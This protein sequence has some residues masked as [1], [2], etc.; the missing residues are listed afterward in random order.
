MACGARVPSWAVRVFGKVLFYI[1][2]FCVR[3]GSDR[4]KVYE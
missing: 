4:L 1:G 3:C 2:G